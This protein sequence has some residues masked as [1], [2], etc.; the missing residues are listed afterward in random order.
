[1]ASEIQLERSGRVVVL[2][3]EKEDTVSFRFWMGKASTGPVSKIGRKNTLKQIKSILRSLDS[4]CVCVC[5]RV[6]E[7]AVLLS[8]KHTHLEYKHLQLHAR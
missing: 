3:R 5:M 7:Y 8:Y 6:C 4:S 2:P 1:M